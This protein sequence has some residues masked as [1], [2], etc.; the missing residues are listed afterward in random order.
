MTKLSRILRILFP[1]RRNK[2]ITAKWDATFKSLG[3]ASLYELEAIEDYVDTLIDLKK[4]K[5]KLVN[6]Y[7]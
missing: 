3:N 5:G 1:A 2:E 6:C 7:E 4:S